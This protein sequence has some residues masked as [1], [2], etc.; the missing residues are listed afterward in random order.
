MQELIS[1]IGIMLRFPFFVVGLI[2]WIV[3]VVPVSIFASVVKFIYVP[4]KL[5]DCS[6]RND[7]D[8][9]RRYMDSVFDFSQTNEMIDMMWRWL[10][11][12]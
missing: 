3:I 8:D 4:I 1:F 6:F 7:A 5:L 2:F 11:H 9:F 10:L 12:A